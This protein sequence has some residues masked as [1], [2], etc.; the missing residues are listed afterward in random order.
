ME[1]SGIIIAS[2]TAYAND[3][4]H[5]CSVRPFQ[6]RRSGPNGRSS[7]AAGTPALPLLTVGCACKP[8]V[9][10]GRTNRWSR[11]CAQA[12]R[13]CRAELH[14]PN[15]LRRRAVRHHQ[16]GS[17]S[18]GG[19]HGRSS[20]PSV[21]GR[22]LLRGQMGH[23]GPTVVPVHRPPRCPPALESLP[24]LASCVALSRQRPSRPPPRRPADGWGL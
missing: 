24:S 11:T 3:S 23:C 20:S 8:R 13:P 6:W 15:R 17:V 19:R 14:G 10:C 22:A 1:V 2:S 4:L 7:S 12:I 21:G 18:G 16:S 9:H 5:A